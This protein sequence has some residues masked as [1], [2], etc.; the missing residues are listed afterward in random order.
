MAISEIIIVCNIFIYF[1]PKTN[2]VH[3]ATSWE[4]QLGNLSRKIDYESSKILHSYLLFSKY[5]GE[6]HVHELQTNNIFAIITDG[7][8][9]FKMAILTWR[10][11]SHCFQYKNFT[12]KHQVLV[13][14]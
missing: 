14:C 2:F 5:G 13:D 1:I 6:H 11:N 12:I 4:R 7:L 9:V 3:I 10:F 8:S